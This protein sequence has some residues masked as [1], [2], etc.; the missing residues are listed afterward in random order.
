MKALFPLLILSASALIALAADGTD[1]PEP[2]AQVFVAALVKEDFAGAGKQFDDTMKT[3]LPTEKLQ[4]VWKKIVGQVGS[5]QKVLRTRTEKKDAYEIVL[6]TCQFEKAKLDAKIVFDKQG[7]VSGLFF[8][9]SQAADIPVPSYAKKEAFR[10]E[11]V[12]VGAGDWELP[13]TLT[14][15]KG[16]GPFPAVVL[17][18][19][20]GPQDRDETIG[21]TK[22]FRDLAWGLAS[23]GV[24]VLRYEKRT[25]QYGPKMAAFKQLTVKEEVIDDAVAAVQLLRKMPAVDGKRIVLLGHSLGALVTPRI[26]QQDGKL[27]GLVLL[28]GPS[29]PLEEVLLTQVDYLLAQQPG[30]EEKAQLE[31]L[32][33]V[34]MRLKENKVT[35][36]TPASELIG[37]PGSYWLDLHNY[38]AAAAASKL[39]LPMLILQGERD[40]QVTMTDF[41]GWQKTMPDRKDVTLKSYAKLNHLFVEGTGKSLPAEYQQTGNVDGAVIDDIA[42][43]VR[44]R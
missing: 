7:R 21:G 36:E 17:V 26:A 8:V 32:R 38:D 22:P 4:E 43:W 29:R 40:Y 28:A 24:A 1:G 9:P 23:Q 20:S 33:A 13:G 10:E 2:R 12:K 42:K 14:V 30:D 31:K 6:V 19:G 41:A 37:A 3:A 44:L 25:L 5:F 27:A 18:H 11:E 34:A 16:E 39:T 35:A 15:P